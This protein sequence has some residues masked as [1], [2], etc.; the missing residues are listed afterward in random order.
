M[1]QHPR[2]LAIFTLACALLPAAAAAQGGPPPAGVRVAE[3]RLVSLAPSIQVPGTVVSRS[4]ARVAAE[5]AGR[6]TWIA[7]IGT[8][9]PAGEPVARIDDAELILQR[10]EYQGLLAAQ[11]SRRGFLQR[12]SER[13]R[14]LA[15]EN[16]VAKNRLDEVESDLQAAVG[17]ITVARA[18]L[19]QIELQLERTRLRAPFG[20]VVT[21]RLRTPGEH[22]GV[23]DE[24]V[25]LVN[26]ADVEVVA[27]APLPSL[28]Y[29]APGAE[30]Q[31]HS[32]WHTGAGTIRTLVPFGDSR[33]HMF[34]LRLSVPAEPWRVGENVRISVPTAQ[35]TEVLAVPRDA[36]VLRREGATVFRVGEDGLAEQ[37][38]VVPGVGADDMIAV[39][40]RLA[41]GDRVVIRGAERLRPGQPVRIVGEGG[42][43]S[44]VPA[45]SG[46]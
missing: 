39:S 40:G 17:D 12:E 31:F 19:G 11:E 8:H 6:L 1:S 7:E 13:L 33:S 46:A 29:I 24:I 10:E 41:P 25:R 32:Q 28:G 30:L 18:R 22:T 21:E 14:R 4:D 27:R 3:A 35:P 37:I 34:E 26:P 5:V 38:D 45:A 15:A 42:E 43:G 36:L 16:D 23:G 20:G 9:I 44:A 2:T